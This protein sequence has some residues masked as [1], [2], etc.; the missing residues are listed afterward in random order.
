MYRIIYPN[1]S[2]ISIIVPNSEILLDLHH[3]AQK[4][5]PNGIR[6]KIISTNDIPQ[7]RTFR[8]AWT[9]DF[10]DYDGIGNNNDNN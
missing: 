1:N 5:V 9:Y 8:D 3:I 6:Y 4:Y 10:N 2:S 7:D